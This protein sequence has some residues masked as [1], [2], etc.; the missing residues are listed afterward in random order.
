MVTVSLPN[1]V[2]CDYT[3]D[4]SSHD[5]MIK[6][7]VLAL[8]F[9]LSWPFLSPGLYVTSSLSPTSCPVTPTPGVTTLVQISVTMR[10]TT[11]RGSAFRTQVNNTLAKITVSAIGW[12]ALVV[13]SK[14]KGYFYLENL[15]L[16]I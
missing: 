10:C 6:E 11:P 1:L 15:V 5:F 2:V 4:M 13:V 7:T 8:Y 14:M 16:I 12:A 3:C 9:R